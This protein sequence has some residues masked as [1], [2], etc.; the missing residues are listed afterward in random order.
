MASPFHNLRRDRR[1][2]TLA[3]FG[4]SGAL[5][6]AVAAVFA[7]VGGVVA[8]SAWPEGP[9]RDEPPSVALAPP[10]ARP[11]PDGPPAPAAGDAGTPAGAAVADGEEDGDG[12]IGGEADDGGGPGATAPGTTQAGDATGG[13]GPGGT[14]A[15]T[16]TP[17][18]S[19]TPTT[20]QPSTPLAAGTRSA[21]RRVGEGVAGGGA[22]AG[23]QLRAVPIVGETVTGV[24]TGAG[25]AVTQAGEVVASLLDQPIAA[26]PL[27]R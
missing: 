15:P 2:A 7:A 23:D 5:L 18:V 9:A 16:P 6:A 26:A 19:G 25:D 27:G 1:R 12:P 3:G 8:F 13:P 10:A 14:A 17:S 20:P 24:S 22:Q 11:A 21:T 4:T